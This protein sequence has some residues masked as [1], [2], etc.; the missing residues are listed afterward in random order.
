[1]PPAFHR[2]TRLLSLLLAGLCSTPLLAAEPTGLFVA[3]GY[4]GRRITSRDGW[5][6]ENDQRWSDQ[7]RDDDNVL[8]NI[9]FGMG[10][11]IAVGGGAALGHIV[12]SRDGREWKEQAPAIRGRVA[13]IAFG[14]N[15]FVAGHDSELLYSTDG[16]T[17]QPGA[18]IVI[19]GSIHARRSVFGSGEAGPRFVLI[20][21]V[22]HAELGK[23]VSWR[24]SSEDGTTITSLA[25]DS[26]PVR[27]IAYG[28]GHFV[29]VG[30][31]GLI[32]SSH[33]GQNWQRHST[34]P[35]C[36]FWRVVWS[37]KRFLASGGGET[38]SSPDALTWTRESLR[39][40]CPLAWAREDEQLLALGFSWG[41]NLH[42]SSDL[43]TWK[44]PVLPPG[45]SLEAVA[46]STGD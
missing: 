17:F 16:E 20:G 29:V 15:R 23:R 34:G 14:S 4:G 46:H 27:D 44:K 40:P 11:F 12:S 3:V 5:T 45:P 32:E 6:W 36:D 37:G 9:A 10:R 19:P 43:L 24:A 2:K 18:R 8:F 39:I 22:D 26:P 1:M 28:S 35:D 38:W 21:D 30:P 41:G 31:N 7:A 42:V 25:V 33:D 13:T